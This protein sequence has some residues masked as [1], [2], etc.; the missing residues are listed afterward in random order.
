MACKTE[1]CL[2]HGLDGSPITWD[3]Y[4]HP[5][6]LLGG[7]AGWGKTYTA[8]GLME[9]MLRASRQGREGGLLVWN[10]KRTSY[11]AWD[12]RLLFPQ[13][14]SDFMLSNVA[15]LWRQSFS[16]YLWELYRYRMAEIERCE[17]QGGGDEFRAAGFAPIT[18]VLEELQGMF[19]ALEKAE[20]SD[21][22]AK[23]ASKAI[24]ADLNVMT[25]LFRASGIRFILV[26]QA[27]TAEG[28]ISTKTKTNATAKLWLGPVDEGGYLACFGKATPSDFANKYRPALGMGIFQAA[29]IGTRAVKIA[30]G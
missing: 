2:G 6:L 3:W 4:R 24:S 17:A 8:K 29:E 18:V 11:A 14:K 19:Q 21:P 20:L 12:G 9:G 26:S 22:K 25:A 27:M 13:W 16:P 30:F 1:V 15:D 10:P 28:G 23:G 5:N 7:A